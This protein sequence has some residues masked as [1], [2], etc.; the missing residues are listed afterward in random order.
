VSYHA[1]RR[2]FAGNAENSFVG[3]GFFWD[4]GA[5]RSCSWGDDVTRRVAAAIVSILLA[6]ALPGLAHAQAWSGLGGNNN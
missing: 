2:L 4:A 1:S 5:A 6:G 3:G